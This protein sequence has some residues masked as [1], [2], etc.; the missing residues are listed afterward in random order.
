MERTEVKLTPEQEK[1]W[2][3][4]FSEAINVGHPQGRAARMAWREVKEAFPELAKF[5]GAKA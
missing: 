5:D 3:H 1:V 4:A 2:Q